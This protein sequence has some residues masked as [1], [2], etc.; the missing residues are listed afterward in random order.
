LKTLENNRHQT[1]PP[2]IYGTLLKGPIMLRPGDT[3]G[4]GLTQKG[5]ADHSADQR[6]DWPQV[7]VL[8]VPFALSGA[9]AGFFLAGHVALAAAVFGAIAVGLILGWWC[10]GLADK[11]DVG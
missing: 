1:V 5:L 6:Q 7:I 4:V 10:R 8:A 9:I 11:G 2:S 3:A